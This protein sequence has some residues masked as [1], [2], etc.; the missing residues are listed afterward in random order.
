MVSLSAINGDAVT[1]LRKSWLN[2][3][4][5]GTVVEQSRRGLCEGVLVYLSPTC[6]SG[7][8]LHAPVQFLVIRHVVASR[9]EIGCVPANV[10]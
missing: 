10:R 9:R 7:K 2:R 3:L 1:G 6:G 4:R 8:D 5:R